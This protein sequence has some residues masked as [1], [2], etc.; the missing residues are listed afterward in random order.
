MTMIDPGPGAEPLNYANYAMQC[1]DNAQS[2]LTSGAMCDIHLVSRTL[3]D[4]LNTTDPVSFYDAMVVVRYASRLSDLDDQ[5]LSELVALHDA[6]N[7]THGARAVLAEF[8]SSCAA[9]MA[10]EQQLGQRPITLADN[11]K[12]VRTTVGAVLE[13]SLTENTAAG[14]R[15]EV[16][17][18]PQ[19][20]SVTRIGHTASGTDGKPTASISAAMIRPGRATLRLIERRP[21]EIEDKS[22]PRSFSLTLIIGE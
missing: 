2:A 1:G 16:K 18:H 5:V 9:R 11:G 7:A 3:E 10:A 21:P 6:D 15:W 8:L 17:G 13:L 12:S 14:Y 22:Q 19:S 20:F 4:L